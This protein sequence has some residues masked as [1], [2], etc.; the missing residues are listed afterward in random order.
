MKGGALRNVKT[1]MTE[2]RVGSKGSCDSL[3]TSVVA[4][5]SLVEV[6]SVLEDASVQSFGGGE[7]ILLP[8]MDLSRAPD[9]RDPPVDNSQQEESN[10]GANHR[11][12]AHWNPSFKPDRIPGCKV[13]VRNHALHGEGHTAVHTHVHVVTVRMRSD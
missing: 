6:I 5:N 9:C 12:S 8:P 7:N 13:Q 2:E 10:A 4:A 3:L 1:L 11:P